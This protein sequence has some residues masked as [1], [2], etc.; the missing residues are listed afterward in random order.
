VATT[1]I[2]ATVQNLVDQFGRKRVPYILEKLGK[3]KAFLQAI[4][5][6]VTEQLLPQI[7][8]RWGTLLL[9]VHTGQASEAE[10]VELNVLDQLLTW[11]ATKT[12]EAVK[13]IETPT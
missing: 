12:V 11:W 7:I 9:K 13:Y 2:T 3:S 5:H 4:N 6:P 8:D 1:D 10:Q